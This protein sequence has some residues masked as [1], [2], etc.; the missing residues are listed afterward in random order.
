[1]WGLGTGYWEGGGAKALG[2][3]ERGGGDV[4]LMEEGR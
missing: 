4:R 1:M 3:G 2:W